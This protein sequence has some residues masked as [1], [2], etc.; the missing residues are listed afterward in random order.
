MSNKNKMTKAIIPSTI[1]R[2]VAGESAAGRTVG[3]SVMMARNMVNRAAPSSLT[4]FST[5]KYATLSDDVF[6]FNR[7]RKQKQNVQYLE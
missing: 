2:P 1:F 6:S 4:C 3:I 7:M 5:A